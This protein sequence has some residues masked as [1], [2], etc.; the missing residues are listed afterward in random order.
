MKCIHTWVFEFVIRLPSFSC[1]HRFFAQ[2]SV[3]PSVPLL[4]Q[5]HDYSSLSDYDRIM[6]K[7][8]DL[9]IQEGIAKEK[10]CLVIVAAEYGLQASTSKRKS[11]RKA[12]AHFSSFPAVKGFNQ[13]KSMFMI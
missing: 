8:H 1:P 3:R 4:S 9:C 5:V 2:I 12:G 11:I 10:E 6:R 13:D 7:I